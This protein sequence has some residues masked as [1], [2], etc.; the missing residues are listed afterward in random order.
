MGSNGT[1]GESAK[2]DN[3]LYTFLQ[4][5]AD[6]DQSALTGT[7]VERFNILS[8]SLQMAFN[9]SVIIGITDTAGSI[10]YVNEHFCRISKYSEQEL[11][12]KNH[13]IVNSGHH[14]KS[15]FRKMWQTISRGDIWEGE[16][17]NQAKDGSPYWVKTTIVPISDQNGYPILYVSIRTDITEGKLAQERLLREMENNYLQTIQA[18]ESFVFKVRKDEEGIIRLIMLEGKLAKKMGMSIERAYDKPLAELF[19]PFQIKALSEKMNRAFDGEILEFKNDYRGMTFFTSLSPITMDG[20]IVE[21]VGNSSD[22]TSMQEAENK[23]KHM[24]Y[25]DYLTDLPNIRLF[26]RDASEILSLA[27]NEQIG[28]LYIKF[29]E[30]EGIAEKFGYSTGEKLLLAVSRNLKKLTAPY[31]SLYR[32]H[33]HGFL[34]LITNPVNNIKFSCEEIYTLASREYSLDNHSIRLTAQIGTAVFPEDGEDSET[35]LKHASAALHYTKELQKN[36]LLY[37]EIKGQFEHRVMLEE[38]LK[39]AIDENQLELFYQPKIDVESGN[40]VGLEALVRWKLGETYINP[41]VFIPLAEKLGMISK[42]GEWVLKTACIQMK[43]WINQGYE[44]LQVAVNISA[45]E[46]EQNDFTDKVKKIVAETTLDPQFLELELTENSVMQRT[47]ENIMKIKELREAGISVAIDDFGTGYSSLA[48]LK[49]FPVS[50]LKIDQTFIRDVFENISNATLVRAMV[51]I[52]DTF[53]LDVVAEGVESRE[54]V[55]FLMEVGCRIV[56]GYYYCR[57]IPNGEIKKKYLKKRK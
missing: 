35:L 14:P 57:P 56:Q 49:E 22:I 8:N 19:D 33:E 3:M 1:L 55:D 37:S 28:L 4:D 9:Q 13:R 26:N 23:I 6:K 27:D 18:M 29:T 46:L 34:L 16:I 41:A 20:K 11:I 32:I 53:Q 42:I 10:I 12:G 51:Q 7:S 54:A 24:A 2:T 38:S 25:Y 52:A 5:F 17:K 30:M 31:G 44:P 39:S 40:I 45:L 15:F 43:E 48:Y 21:V 47:E 50:T 36:Y